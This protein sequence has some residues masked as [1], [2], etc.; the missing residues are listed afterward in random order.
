MPP[1]FAHSYTIAQKNGLWKIQCSCGTQ[2]KWITTAESQEWMTS[3]AGLRERKST[4]HK[5]G[6]ALGRI[7]EED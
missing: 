7:A 2:T 6:E 4:I 1:K 3:H 5:H